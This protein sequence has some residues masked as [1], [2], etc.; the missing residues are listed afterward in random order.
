MP[1]VIVTRPF[2]HSIVNR[3]EWPASS[4]FS[5]AAAPCWLLLTISTIAFPDTSPPH[6]LS[7]SSC[8]NEKRVNKKVRCLIV[9]VSHITPIKCFTVIHCAQIIH[10]RIST[11]AN[12]NLHNWMNLGIV[13]WTKL[14]KPWNCSNGFEPWLP[15]LRARHS[16]AEL[17]HLFLTCISS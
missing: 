3:F 2:K 12:I 9:H 8:N 16:T 15:Q 10:S 7:N 5:I 6:G 17:P 1:T 11:S 14:L 13:K 4:G